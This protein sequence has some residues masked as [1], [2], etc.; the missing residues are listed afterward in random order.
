VI[1][2]AVGANG[3][4][5]DL[6]AAK[7]LEWRD[8]YRGLPGATFDNTAKNDLLATG[9][10]SLFQTLDRALYAWNNN[11]NIDD[12]LP[13]PGLTVTSGPNVIYLEWEDMSAVNDPDKGTPD[14]D[15]YN[16]YRKKGEFLV[17]TYS[18]INAAGEHLKWELI[19]ANIPKTES[20][21]TDANVI[22]GEAYHYAVTAVDQQ[23]LESSRYANRSELPAFAFAPGE[24]TA[25]RVR[26]VPNP[27]ILKA[28]DF[29]FTGDDNKLLFANLPPYCTL[30]IY[31]AT[32]DLIQTIDHQTGSADASWDQVTEYNQLVASGVYILKI[33]NARD[34]NGKSMPGAVEKFVIIR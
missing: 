12:P 8:W 1:V 34:L 6:A 20:K 21:Y 2:Y 30:R 4:S 24:P 13:A 22:R 18:E 3:I 28:G 32:G 27:Y 15:H 16:V 25:A 29:N 17:D 11:L 23:G 9:K 7:G 19:A 31:T 5:T 33:D 14:L 10:D 26:I